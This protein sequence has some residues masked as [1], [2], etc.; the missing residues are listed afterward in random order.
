MMGVVIAITALIPIVG[1]FI[2]CFIGAVLILIDSPTKAL[3]FVI[4]EIV[5]QQ[6]EG[7]L[8]YPKVVGSSIGLPAVLVLIAVTIGGGVFGVVG[9]LIGV[10]LT[11]AIYRIVSD[12][13]KKPKKIKE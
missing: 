5:M 2:G 3:V 1:A 4:F 7:N 9:L 10:P 6:I 13:I 11:A 12:D 8:I